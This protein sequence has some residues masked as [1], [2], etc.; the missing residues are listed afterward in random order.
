M[1]EPHGEAASTSFLDSLGV[2]AQRRAEPRTS[3][4]IAGAGCALAILGVL[5][6]SGDTG[7]PDDFSGDFNKV[8]GIILS[9][10]VVAGGYVALAQAERGAI[11]TGGAVAAGLGVPALLFFLTFDQDGL[12]PYSTEA[13][14]Y[15][16][17]IAWLGSYAVG[18]G[19]GRPFFLGAGLLGLWASLLQVTEKVFDFPFVAIGGFFGA[20]STTTAFDSTGSEIGGD[21]FG[22]D[23]GGGG[24]DE[25]GFGTPTFDIPDPT[26]IGILSLGL[27]IAYLV[28]CRRLDR[29]GL[30]GAAT[31]FALAT[32]PTLFVG[33]LF[34]ADDLEAAGTGL[35]LMGIGFGLAYHGA[36]VWRRATTWI[37]G[38]V[39]ALGAAVFLGDMADDATIGGMLFVAAGVGLVFAGHLLAARLGEADEMV[40]TAP[41]PATATVTTPGSPP[42]PPAPPAA[43]PDDTA[44]APPVDP[45]IPPPPG[46][47]GGDD[48]RPAPPF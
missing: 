27:G 9:L 38:A 10:L 48:D 17:T 8:P 33:T 18:P 25:P 14:L 1:T 42:A 23:F 11:A 30:V 5:L 26:T 34:L 39:T 45:T 13:I 29:R 6:V 20:F 36:S 32:L 12:P 40:V 3:I 22:T 44:W 35:L 21:D 37:G 41:V 16:S 28:V 19:R 4:A 2:R 31:P 47:P 24:F 7:V 46:A 43:A 15:V